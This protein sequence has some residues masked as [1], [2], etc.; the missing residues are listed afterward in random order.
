M[1]GMQ[2]M[3]A[4]VRSEMISEGSGATLELRGLGPHLRLWG[5]GPHFRLRGLRPHFRLG[6]GAHFRLRGHLRLRSTLQRKKSVRCSI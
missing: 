5:L 6:P 1:T 3:A 4:E 2:S